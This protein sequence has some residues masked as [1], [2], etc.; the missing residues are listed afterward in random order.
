MNRVLTIFQYLKPDALRFALHNNIIM[1]WSNLRKC[2]LILWLAAGV[3]LLW[4][5]WKFYILFHPSVWPWVNLPLLKFQIIIN[6]IGFCLMFILMIPCQI[7]QGRP[8]AEQNLPYFIL[9]AFVLIFIRDGY[10]IGIFSPATV[11]AFVC[12]VGI[13]LLLFQRKFVYPPLITA[14]VIFSIL[15]YQTLIGQLAYGPIF[16][17]LLFD[18]YPYSIPFWVGSMVYCIVPIA[19]CCLILCEILL[20]QWRH[21][22][23]LITRL[24]QT[25]PLTNLMNRRH[26]NQQLQQLHQT[27]HP[28]A[29]ILLDLDYFKQIND[30][31]GHSAGDAVL[32]LVAKCLT[33][34]LQAVDFAARYGGE[35]FIIALPKVSLAEACAVAERCRL[36]IQNQQLEGYL[37]QG[38]QLTASFGVA[39]SFPTTLF[40][41][42]I[43]NADIALYQAKQQGRN[44]VQCYQDTG[45]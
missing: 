36:E 19:L 6:A 26:F 4:L 34:N 1:N 42:I 39:M 7:F 3:H 16:S 35:E 22:E 20:I 32:Q 18:N 9:S 31:F 23:A 45:A 11:C 5:L 14:L 27:Q 24:S 15:A 21:R 13:G 40:G 8:W 41:N 38:M 37:E 29:I 17:R 10:L 12:I 30:Q 44:Q 43:Q 2:L 28:Y 33:Q 25:D